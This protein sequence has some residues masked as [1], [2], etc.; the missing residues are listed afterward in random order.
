[1][2]HTEADRK[3]FNQHQEQ[4]SYKRAVTEWLREYPQV[5]ELNGGKFYIFKDGQQVEVNV[6]A[7]IK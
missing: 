2:A 1:M 6:F 4:V 7:E 5:G 3:A